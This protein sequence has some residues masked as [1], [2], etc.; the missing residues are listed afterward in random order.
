V[1]G[2]WGYAEFLEAIAD[3]KHLEHDDFV[4]WAGE[5][6]PNEFDLGLT[7]KS[8]RRGLLDLGQMG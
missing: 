3:P 5:F 7:S 6:D 8:L 4:E 1:G 2:A